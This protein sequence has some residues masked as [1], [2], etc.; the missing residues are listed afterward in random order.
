M[1]ELWGSLIPLAMASAIL[2]VQIAITILM[3]RTP[4]GRPRAIAWVS[5]MTVVRLAQ[6]LVFGLI[7]ERAVDDGEPGT[8]AVEAALLLVVSVMF[9]ISAVR[10]LARQPDE[11]EPPPGWMLRI[12]LLSPGKA[13]LLGAGLVGLSPKLWAFTLAAI[14]AIKD[15]EPAAGAGLVLFV[16]FMLA[17][18]SIH[19]AAI[20]FALVDPNRA[21]AVLGGVGGALERHNRTVLIVLGLGFGAWFLV[22]SL[23]AWGIL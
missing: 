3:L 9:F 5:G 20:G 19:L 15:A 18:Q 22:K 2:P 16:V 4:G 11:D 21:N 1:A 17:A 7:L 6:W 10:K 8:S 14:G 13:F 23:T 12:P